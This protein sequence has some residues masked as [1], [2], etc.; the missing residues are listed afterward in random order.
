MF[1]HCSEVFTWGSKR[2][3]PVI[4]YSCTTTNYLPGGWDWNNYEKVCASYTMFMH[5]CKIITWGRRLKW[6]WRTPCNTIVTLQLTTMLLWLAKTHLAVSNYHQRHEQ[7]THPSRVC[8]PCLAARWS[9]VSCWCESPYEQFGSNTLRS[10]LLLRYSSNAWT[11]S[12]ACRCLR[13]F[14]DELPITDLCICNYLDLA[15]SL[16]IAVSQGLC[17]KHS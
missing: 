15:D 6:L 9:G 5:R 16:V 7:L 4:R 2:S 3:L 10:S 11:S 17:K 1:M 14:E 12:P 8:I 13:N